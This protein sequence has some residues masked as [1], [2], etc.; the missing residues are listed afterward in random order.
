MGDRV[1]KLSIIIPVYNAEK[2]LPSCV[3]SIIAAT[4]DTAEILLVNDGSKDGSKKLIESYQDRYPN[5]V[6]AISKPNSGSGE[7]RNLGLAK[8]TG[9]YVTFIDSD[10]Y[11]D[12]DYFEKFVDAIERTGAD[13]V[14]GGYK[15]IVDGKEQ[16]EVVLKDVPWARYQILAPWAK[17][18]NLDFI[19]RNNL[20]FVPLVLG[21]D[22]HFV[23]VAYSYANKVAVLSYA[24]YN[25]ICNRESITNTKHKGLRRDIKLTELLDRIDADVNKR[26]E[27]LNLH[28]LKLGVYY[29]LRSGRLA[30]KE[31]FMEE[32]VKLM[33]WYREHNV[34]LNF[35]VTSITT[36]DPLQVRLAV[37]IYLML[38]KAHL[39]SA[40]ASVYCKGVVKE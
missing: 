2:W 26:D 11:V 38:A 22:D 5:R 8:A 29:M 33:D 17:I 18:F 9:K 23:T 4:D 21:D 37:K 12:R 7:T 27:L 36:S 15:R 16:F 25:F 39:I 34:S 10:D 14:V 32:H 6:I 35:P 31:R 19:R 30:T 3:D 24:G 1:K 40:F 28:Y 20:K 13:V